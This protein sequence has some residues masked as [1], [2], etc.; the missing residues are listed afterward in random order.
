MKK[1]FLLLT[2]AIGTLNNIYAQ[3][4]CANH[5]ADTWEML[6][7]NTDFKEAHLAPE[8]IDYTPPANA[9]MV[10]FETQQAGAPG[11]AY[12]M[13]S[14]KP[15]S[16]VLV[17]FH[18]WWGLNDYIKKEAE[19]WQKMLGNVDV[20]A[21]DLFDGQVADS[22]ALA[23]KISSAMD[24]KRGEAIISG[25]LRHIGND[26][27]VATLGWCFGGAWAFTA[28]VMA[29]NNSVGVVDYYGFP[30]KDAAKIKPLQSDVLYIYATKDQFITANLVADLQKQ[31]EATGHKFTMHSFDAVHA[32]ANPSNPKHDALSAKQAEQFAKKFLADKLQLN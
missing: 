24:T 29:G 1:I 5:S 8:P 19:N 7:L 27:Q 25:L 32:F 28:G 4:C 22:P 23:S 6:A 14:D 13:P 17:I 2:L 21:V 9:G 31:V 3:S 26:K 12:Y 15:T 11:M 30:E 20:Y 16:K 10:K 18:E